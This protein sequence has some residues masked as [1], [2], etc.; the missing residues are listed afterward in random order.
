MTYR[1]I[2]NKNSQIQK[3]IRHHP[4]TYFHLSYRKIRKNHFKIRPNPPSASTIVE[5]TDGDS[6]SNQKIKY[7]DKKEKYWRKLK[8]K[9]KRESSWM[10]Y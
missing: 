9:R 4:K 8:K 10:A 7:Y 3:C 5:E 1:I 2:K 6:F